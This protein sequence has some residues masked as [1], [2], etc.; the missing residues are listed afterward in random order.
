M[1]GGADNIKGWI[2]IPLAEIIENAI[3]LPI[4]V[5]N[6]ANL[7]GLGETAYGAAKGCREVVFL[8][9]GT[10]IGGAVIIDGELYRGY[11]NKGTE[12]GHIVLFGDG[13]PCSCGS[14]G[15]LEQYA[16]TSALVRRFNAYCSQQNISH[17]FTIN[18]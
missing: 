6:D 16:S 5:D 1:L 8:T 2:N 10:G 3:H 18:G 7:M 14:F 11:K 15:C 9:I 13:E 4:G 12:L 17:D